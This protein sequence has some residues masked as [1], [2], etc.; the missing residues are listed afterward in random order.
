M[1]KGIKKFLAMVLMVI[2]VVNC[3]SCYTFADGFGNV[4]LIGNYQG[5]NNTF[6]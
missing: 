3:S 2:L 5:G 4:M 1:F 6:L